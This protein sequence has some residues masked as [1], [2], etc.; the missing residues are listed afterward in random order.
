MT[1]CAEQ[2]VDCFGEYEMQSE[3]KP[4]TNSVATRCRLRASLEVYQHFFKSK[5]RDVVFKKQ[6]DLVLKALEETD[7]QDEVVEE[8][9]LTE[10]EQPVS[11]AEANQESQPEKVEETEPEVVEA[12]PD[13][14]EC[15]PPEPE[16]EKPEKVDKHLLQL[17]KNMKLL[18]KTL[19]DNPEVISCAHMTSHKKHE[20]EIY[21]PIDQ[22]PVDEQRLL[23]LAKPTKVRLRNTLEGFRRLMSREKQERIELQLAREAVTTEKLEESSEKTEETEELSPKVGTRSESEKAAALL[24]MIERKLTADMLDEIAHELKRKL[25]RLVKKYKEPLMVTSYWINLRDIVLTQILSSRGPLACQEELEVINKF[26]SVIADFIIK[27]QLRSLQSQGPSNI[28][29]SKPL[30][31]VQNNEFL[32]KLASKLIGKIAE[33]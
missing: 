24:V 30:H 9:D 32:I 4:V 21:V 31:S 10:T 28:S 2:E 14:N 5:E 12:T 27:L 3:H 29:C 6:Y 13:P 8:T 15:Q 16:E 17:V 11:K 25:P 1:C 23:E 33:K 26:A 19:E 7:Q 22:R 18:E 20:G